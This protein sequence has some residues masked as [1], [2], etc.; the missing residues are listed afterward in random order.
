MLCRNGRHYDV[1]MVTIPTRDLGRSLPLSWGESVEVVSGC[2]LRQASQ[3]VAQV[4]EGID[5]SA[6][7]GDDDRVDDRRALAG[8]G[9]ADKKPI[10]FVMRSYP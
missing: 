6:L 5:P 2:H 3:D 7:T 10:L 8:V 9:M 4:C 1:P